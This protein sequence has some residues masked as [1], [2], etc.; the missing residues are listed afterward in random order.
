MDY[1][2]AYTSTSHIAVEVFILMIFNSVYS[3]LSHNL[4][5]YLTPPLFIIQNHICHDLHS[6]HFLR[7]TKNS[8]VNINWPL[9]FLHTYYTSLRQRRS[10]KARD[11]SGVAY[12][13]ITELNYSMY[14]FLL[15]VYYRLQIRECIK[16]RLSSQA[17]QHNS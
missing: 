7:V 14:I 6:V 5:H 17:T 3:K 4:Q 16:C 2:W 1:F 15:I 9:Y 12:K 10:K 11:Y 13:S 8:F